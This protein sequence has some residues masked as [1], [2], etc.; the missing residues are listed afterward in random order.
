MEPKIDELVGPQ[1]TP[2]GTLANEIMAIM[3]DAVANDIEWSPSAK[4]E[5]IKLQ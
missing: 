1:P 2:E 3:R 4:N 5:Y